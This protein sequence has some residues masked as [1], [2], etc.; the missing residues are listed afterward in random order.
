LEHTAVDE[1]LEAGLQPYLITVQEEIARV[2][3]HLTRVYLRDEPQP[4]RLVGVARAAML[5]AEQ[6]QQ[7]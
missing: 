6:Q 2:C 3:D 7:Q 4:G 1:V 5:M